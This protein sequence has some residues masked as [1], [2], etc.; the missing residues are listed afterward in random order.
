MHNEIQV[1]THVYERYFKV[2]EILS[3]TIVYANM[4]S[5]A[6]KNVYQDF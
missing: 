3:C 5:R 4:S 6:R 1:R 2:Q